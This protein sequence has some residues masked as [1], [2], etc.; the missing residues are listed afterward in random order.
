METRFYVP[1]LLALKNIVANPE[2]FNSRLPLIENHP[3]FQTVDIK[4]DIDV[5]LVAK[6]AEVSLED[7][8]ALNPSA[9]RPVIFAAGTPQILLPWDNAAVFQSNLEAYGVGRL[10]SWTVWVAPATMKPADAASRVGMSEE[11][12]RRANNI[13]PR[14]MIKIGSSLLVTRSK[15]L[16]TDVTEHV[17]DNGQLSFSPDVILKRT[18]LKAGK[19]DSVASLAKRY[20]VSPAS[21]ADWNNMNASA[22]FK[23]GQQIVLFLPA[24]ASALVQSRS[25]STGK[26]S[27]HQAKRKVTKSTR[28]ARH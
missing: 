6:L 19:K 18:V 7:F 16:E 25:R 12:L 22:A 17:A 13:P 11:D 21:V 15:Q 26:A 10:A 2:A 20:R 8:K 3:Y 9:N 27:S 5:A 28:V 4:R 24:R 23:T 1:K 14:M